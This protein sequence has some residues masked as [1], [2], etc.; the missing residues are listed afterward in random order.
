M[1]TKV[2]KMLTS[3]LVVEVETVSNANPNINRI[4]C[5]VEIK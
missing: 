2:I 4:L 5:N 1:T 3:Q